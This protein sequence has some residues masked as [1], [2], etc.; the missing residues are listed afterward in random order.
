[1]ITEKD[2]IADI[3]DGFDDRLDQ[4]TFMY[5]IKWFK[6]NIWHEPEERPIEGKHIVTK[7]ADDG[8]Y[9]YDIDNVSWLDPYRET[10]E[11]YCINNKIKAWCYIE[12]LLPK[13]NV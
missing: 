10:W 11:V 12:D 2:I 9:C 4:Y 7:S 8:R 6:E 1:M 3:N 5:A 13:K